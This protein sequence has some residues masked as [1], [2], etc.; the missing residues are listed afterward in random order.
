[1]LTGALFSGFEG[2]LIAIALSSLLKSPLITLGVSAVILGTLIFAQT[3]RWIEK[4]DLLIV[5]GI[6]FAVVFFIPFLHAGLSSQQVGILAITA[7]LIAV[8]F[9]ALFRLI[10][11]LLSL[12]F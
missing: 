10:Y 12:I 2:A 3:R 5:G 11:K 6:S 7:G 8:A 1:M 9:T 4:I